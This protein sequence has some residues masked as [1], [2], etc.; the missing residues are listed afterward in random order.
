MFLTKKC[1][2]FLN[3]CENANPVNDEMCDSTGK[4]NYE[5]KFHGGGNL[6]K[7]RAQVA[8]LLHHKMSS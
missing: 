8:V 1:L 2:S 7:F 4:D 3:S 5:M 6:L